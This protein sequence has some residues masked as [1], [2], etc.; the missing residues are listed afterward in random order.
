[1]TKN[2][3][4]DLNNLLFEQLERLNDESLDL[5]QELKRAKAISDVS[6]KV[7]QSADLSF[8]V[9]KLR[10]EMTGN[11]ETPEMLEV[12]KLETKND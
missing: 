8:K 9:M 6:D 11:V 4:E 12:K 3:M 5:E 2:K 7:I 10:A 1:M